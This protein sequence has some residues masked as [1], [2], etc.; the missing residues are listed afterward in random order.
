[1]SERMMLCES[2]EEMYQTLRKFKE[3]FNAEYGRLSR[4][5]RSKNGL[6]WRDGEE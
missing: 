4:A 5:D 1:M 3:E 2:E 6:R